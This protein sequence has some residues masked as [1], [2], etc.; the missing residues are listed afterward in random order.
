M[1]FIFIFIFS[2]LLLV[3]C[4]PVEASCCPS[5]EI[6]IQGNCE[7]CIP[8][9]LTGK[10]GDD[11]KTDINQLI[12]QIINAVLGVVGSLA[13]LMF[14]YGGIVWMTAA[15]ANEKVQKGKDI[16]LWATIGL[17]IIFSSYALVDFVL[18]NLIGGK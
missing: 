6:T 7:I 11:G 1:K 13:L 15:G 17:I 4:V 3:P 14:I 9:P 5:G 16:L 18:N 10:T 12:G 2:S 8:N